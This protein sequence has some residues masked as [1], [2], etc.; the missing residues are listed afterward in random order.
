MKNGTWIIN[1]SRGKIVNEEALLEALYSGKLTGAA[2]D[3]LSTENTPSHPQSNKLIEYA[4]SHNNLLITPH[5]AGSTF[6]SM[7]MTGLH[8]AK[9]VIKAFK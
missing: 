9:K 1:I 3:V 4:R 2:N 6:E 7:S 8:I 5:I